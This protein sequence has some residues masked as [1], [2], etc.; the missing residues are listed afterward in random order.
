MFIR[1]KLITRKDL[2]QREVG[3]ET[4]GIPTPLLLDVREKNL[5]NNEPVYKKIAKQF[6]NV[7]HVTR[8]L[9]V[10]DDVTRGMGLSEP[11]YRLQRMNSLINFDK[12][13]HNN[14]KIQRQGSVINRN[15]SVDESKDSNILTSQQIVGTK[16]P[17]KK[18]LKQ[19]FSTRQNSLIPTKN[20]EPELKRQRSL[21]NLNQNSNKDQPK[22]QRQRSLIDLNQLKNRENNGLKSKVQRSQV[23]GE[24]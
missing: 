13:K 2:L 7:D 12:T 18:P 8:G 22:I 24:I 3:C 23:S 20:T 11:T 14:M 16:I 4:M 17:T 9:G 6:G 21:M 1:P 10:S 5:N 15:G 19:S